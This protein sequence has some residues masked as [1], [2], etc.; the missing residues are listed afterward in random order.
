VAASGVW[1]GAAVGF[2]ASFSLFLFFHMFGEVLF[3]C[4][5]I[6]VRKDTIFTTD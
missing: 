4:R 6:L 2:L 5:L 3:L 1:E